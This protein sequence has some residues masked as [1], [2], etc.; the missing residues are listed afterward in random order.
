METTTR[1]PHKPWLWLCLGGLALFLALLAEPSSHAT[2]QTVP[3]P[4][5]PTATETVTET[6][7]PVETVVERPTPTAT[8]TA[9]PTEVVSATAT[10]SATATITV[11]VTSTPT[12]T[13]TPTRTSVPLP[14]LDLI[15]YTVQ[16]GETLSSIARRYYTTVS[17]LVSLNN[18]S[19]PNRIYVGQRLR[20]P[21]PP[22][23][24]LPY[25]RPTPTP[26]PA[27]SAPDSAADFV[28][29]F[30]RYWPT[31]SGALDLF[32]PVQGVMYH[33][34]LE[35]I[36]FSQSDAEGIV[37]Q[38]VDEDGNLLAERETIGG[39]GLNYD[40]FQTYLRFDVTET[41]PAL[42]R[43]F[44]VAQGAGADEVVEIPLTL[45]PGQRTLDMIAPLVGEVLCD[46]LYAA[47]YATSLS[48]QLV[49]TIGSR[50]RV[51]ELEK[52]DLTAKGRY[53]SFTFSQDYVVAKAEPLLIGAYTLDEAG[54]FT[55]FT[56]IPVTIYGADS[57]V[58]GYQ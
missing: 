36:G 34:P 58:C 14:T 46:S 16:P 19:N 40:F 51:E 12:V 48:D 20:I 2:A 30:T 42:L 3:S 23:A 35:V 31:P 38:L 8:M 10:S 18:L 26:I 5:T 50:T 44:T 11:T 56:R 1:S 41:Q 25:V 22:R 39:A 15:I 6:A 4:L 17:L 13:A 47:G 21:R 24:P 7:T 45:L 27:D 33:S 37:V 32:S 53:G 54:L 43:I 28:N 29:P 55:D 49:L 52:V 57:E 9:T